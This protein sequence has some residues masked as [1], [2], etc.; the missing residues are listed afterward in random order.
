MDIL[1]EETKVEKDKAESVRQAVKKDQKN[2]SN[3]PNVMQI[4]NKLTKIDPNGHKQEC[5]DRSLLELLAKTYIPF[6]VVDSAEWKRFIDTLDKTVNQKTART[7]SRQM[8]KFADEVLEKVKETVV[9]FCTASLALTT[10]LWTS[11]AHDSY[12]SVT[13]HF[14]DESFRLHR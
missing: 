12:I 4:F 13:I 1:E 14:V 3:Q 7:Y 9:K 8:S 10:D 11:R 5:Y 6:N 2:I